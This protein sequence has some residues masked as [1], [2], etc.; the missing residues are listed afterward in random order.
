MNGFPGQPVRDACPRVRFKRVNCFEK[1]RIII[2]LNLSTILYNIY[3]LYFNFFLQ[4]FALSTFLLA[5]ESYNLSVH[6]SIRSDDHFRT[7]LSCPYDISVQSRMKNS[8]VPQISVVVFITTR[9]IHFRLNRCSQACRR[10]VQLNLYSTS[11]GVA[12]AKKA[13]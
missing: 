6:L 7:V 10:N 3:S 5:R 13:L 9:L 2:T 8:S 12:K 1:K 11:S 4:L